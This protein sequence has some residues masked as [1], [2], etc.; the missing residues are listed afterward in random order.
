VT[1][2]FALLFAVL[3]FMTAPLRAEEPREA[4]FPLADRPSFAH[5]DLVLEKLVQEK[6]QGDANDFCVIGQGEGSPVRAWVYWKQQAALIL[7]EPVTE[8]LAELAL[9]RRYLLLWRDVAEDPMGSSYIVTPGW[10]MS[11]LE[12]CDK[13]GSH[14]RIMRKQKA[15]R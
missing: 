8:G 9:S 12:A 10:V 3:V 6:G 1:T 7:W 2:R 5:A 13:T 14:Y 4:F 11:L 15:R